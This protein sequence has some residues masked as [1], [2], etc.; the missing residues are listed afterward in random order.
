MDPVVAVSNAAGK[1][2]DTISVGIN[3]ATTRSRQYYKR[4]QEQGVPIVSD[5]FAPY[6]T[7]LTQQTSLT[8]YILLGV[9]V[10]LVFAM[11]FK[12]DK[13]R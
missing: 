11:I 4:L 2:F 5:L 12:N 10:V 7:D 6:R 3:V 9:L 1:L 8:L 13:K